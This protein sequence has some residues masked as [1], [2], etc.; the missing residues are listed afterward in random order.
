ME[1]GGVDYSQKFTVFTDGSALNNKAQAPAGMAFYIP[2]MKRLISKSMIATNNQAELEAI[3]YALWYVNE[4]VVKK[5]LEIPDNIIYI[6]TDSNYSMSAISGKWKKLKENLK[7][8]EVCRRIIEE[9]GGVGVKVIFIH[10]K[11]HTRKK[12][13]VSVNNDI[14]D[15]EARRKAE[16]MKGGMSEEDENDS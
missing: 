1:G 4:Q 6:F 12:D 9:V 10:V 5:K 2:S 13:F 14:V 3:R 15:Q 8:I 16:E 11:A 7:K